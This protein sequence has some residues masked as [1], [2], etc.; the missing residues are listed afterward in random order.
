MINIYWINWLK[1][2]LKQSDGFKKHKPPP[3]RGNKVLILYIWKSGRGQKS[4]R[5]NEL[6]C[7]KGNMNSRIVNNVI[8][9]M[10]WIVW[11]KSSSLVRGKTA[12]KQPEKLKGSNKG[13]TQILRSIFCQRT[14]RRRRERNTKCLISFSIGKGVI[15]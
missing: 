6:R 8:N 3:K 9:T 13:R 2:L 4:C 11:N 5:S 12:W 7:E 10:S 14:W 15:W 1:I